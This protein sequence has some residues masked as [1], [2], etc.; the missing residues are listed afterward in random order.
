MKS[1][2][3]KLKINDEFTKPIKKQTV[4]NNIKQN[5]PLIANY[6]FMCDLLF[7]PTAQMGYKY[8]LVI[9]DLASDKFDIEPIK[10][11]D[12][13]TVLN[14]MKKFMPAEFSNNLIHH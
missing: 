1:L 6:N 5:I 10:N 4:F 7:L 14:A 2:K 8:L 13:S 12:S 11:K 3:S 9:V